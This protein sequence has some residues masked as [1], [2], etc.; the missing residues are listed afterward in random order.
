MWSPTVVGVLSVFVATG[1]LASQLSIIGASWPGSTR[2]MSLSV[3]QTLLLNETRPATTETWMN[4]SA[5]IATIIPL[6]ITWVALMA[7]TV[8]GTEA[9]PASVCVALLMGCCTFVV[10][11]CVGNHGTPGL[12][13]RRSWLV[14]RVM[15]GIL[16]VATPALFVLFAVHLNADILYVAPVVGALFTIAGAS[17]YFGLGSNHE[18]HEASMLV[19]EVCLGCTYVAGLLCLAVIAFD[20]DE[21]EPP[22]GT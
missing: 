8:L 3:H 21:I 16:L 18:K 7:L 9:D 6:V 2:L 17:V 10:L 22:A 12:N 13:P 1:M 11:V 14:H 19:T 5:R 20:A 15:T 4:N